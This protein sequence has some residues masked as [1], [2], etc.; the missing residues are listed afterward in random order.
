M[1]TWCWG[2]W[3]PFPKVAA[4]IE[5]ARAEFYQTSCILSNS[6]G[7]LSRATEIPNTSNSPNFYIDWT[8]TVCV[9]KQK[10]SYIS[11]FCKDLNSSGLHNQTEPLL[12]YH[13]E[14]LLVVPHDQM[15]YTLR[16]RTHISPPLKCSLLSTLLWQLGC[17]WWR[18][19][20]T[21][22]QLIIKNYKG[23]RTDQPNVRWQ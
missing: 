12:V 18:S 5:A 17:F 3:G 11:T 16:A 2:G 6:S 19:R 15:L 8:T 14:A 9:G 4:D 10:L 7:K 23:L 21:N 20:I 1:K 13:S 22:D